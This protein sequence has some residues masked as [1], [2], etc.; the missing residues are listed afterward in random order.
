[1]NNYIVPLKW[2][3][4]VKHLRMKLAAT[5]IIFGI[6]TIVVMTLTTR[7]I[8]VN[9]IL[10]E[11]KVLRANIEENIV[12][13][14][15]V[16]DKAHRIFQ[17]I[18]SEEMEL[19]LRE[20]SAYYETNPDVHTWPLDEIAQRYP[21]MDFYV[22]NNEGKVEVTTHKPSEG[23][24]FKECC[25][26]FVKL[27]QQRMLTDDFYFDGLEI[28]VAE[29]SQN[30]YSYL[31]TPDHQYL[32]EFGVGF[33]ETEVAKQFNYEEMVARLKET[34]ADLTELYILTHDGFVLNSDQTLKAYSDLNRDLQQAFW[35]TVE[36]EQPHEQQN[37]EKTTHRFITYHADEARGNATH[38]IVYMTYNN[39]SEVALL[40]RN[41]VQFWLML[42]T[43]LLT[44]GILLLAILK[45]F[46]KTI[47]LATFDTLTG[48]YNRASYLQHMD[49]LIA[50]RHQF[51]IGLQL[52]DLDHFKQV[53]DT[54]GH[55]E[56][57]LVLKETT[58]KSNP[59]LW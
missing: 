46:N 41:T 10:D 13:D 50:N 59:M 54:F 27:I 42:L 49:E 16:M 28:S 38:R 23:M 32:L 19:G 8:L 17:D 34:H 31:A 39:V 26:E 56:G 9:D 22:L 1:M 30:M 45:L 24:D 48:A 15:N 33:D 47:R 21:N 25:T 4:F 57:D 11:Q 6:I 12:A 35:Q 58:V 7:Y 37:G 52:I 55:A 2:V 43:G 29:G 36:T 53:N 40:Q 51:P 14:L 3:A 18:E 44:T 5:L 20:L